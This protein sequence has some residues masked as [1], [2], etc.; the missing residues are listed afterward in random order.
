MKNPFHE[1]HEALATVRR[2]FS[3]VASLNAV[4]MFAA[5]HACETAVATLWR[6]AT[7]SDFPYQTYPRHKPGHWVETLAIKKY[8]SPDSQGFIQRLDSY[9]PD[10][11]RYDTTQAF[12]EHTKPESSGRG[13]E[14]VAGVERFVQETEQLL[15]KPEVVNQ[16][17]ASSKGK[18]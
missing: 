13:E 17:R 15:G 9:A 6:E 14:V 7:G 4:T 18:L 3:Q 8:Y 5:T 12:H 1:A 2:E 10:K 11:V 16:L